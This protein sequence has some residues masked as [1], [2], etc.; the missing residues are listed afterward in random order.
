MVK[1]KYSS[2]DMGMSFVWLRAILRIYVCEDVG[3]EH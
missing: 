3:V 2:T 1:D